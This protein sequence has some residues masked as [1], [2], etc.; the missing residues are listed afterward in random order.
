MEFLEFLEEKIHLEPHPI[1]IHFPIA[2]Y[3]LELVLLFCWLKKKDSNYLNF[4]RFTFRLGYL[5]MIVAMVAGF[6][7]AGGLTGIRGRV[8]YHFMA[9]ASV[10]TLYTL[11]AF[12]WR[13][14][15]VDRPSYK[16]TQ[17]LFALAGNILVALTGYLGGLLVYAK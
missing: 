3:F 9:A 15:K 16:Q 6:H 4:A 5:F 14:G 12:F 10:F 8:R 2:F 13:F 1:F 11:R 17:L 7:D